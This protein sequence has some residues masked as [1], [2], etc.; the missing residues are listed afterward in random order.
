MQPSQ[1]WAMRIAEGRCADV[2]SNLRL[3][4]EKWTSLVWLCSMAPHSSVRHVTV[5]IYS[6]LPEM[7]DLTAKSPL[8]TQR[9]KALYQRERRN[10]MTWN[11][12]FSST[13]QLS[14]RAIADCSLQHFANCPVIVFGGKM[15]ISP[16][17]FHISPPGRRHHY[18]KDILKESL[19]CNEHFFKI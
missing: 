10:H 15:L 16:L 13:R 12:L 7:V 11:S 14:R 5:V 8:G 4:T 17:H 9:K 2:E 1:L 6:P 18:C 3:R 19:F